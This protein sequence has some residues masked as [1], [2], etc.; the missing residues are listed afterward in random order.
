MTVFVLSGGVR[1]NFGIG[2]Y[3][4]VIFASAIE[5]SITTSCDPGMLGCSL[6]H[7]LSTFF[8]IDQIGFV[9]GNPRVWWISEEI[10]L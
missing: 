1:S 7:N 3:E 4:I 10:I 2:L 6:H 8:L 5:K 9:T